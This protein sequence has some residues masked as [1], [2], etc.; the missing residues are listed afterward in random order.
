MQNEFTV[1]PIAIFEGQENFTFLSEA[2]KIISEELHHL[3]SDGLR[4]RG[5]EYKFTTKV[6]VDLA[7]LWAITPLECDYLHNL[8]VEFCPYCTVTCAKAHI[9][10]INE[11]DGVR[12]RIVPLADSILGVQPN[13]FIFCCLHMRMRITERLLLLMANS[14]NNAKSKKNESSSPGVSLLEA[15]LTELNITHLKFVPKKQTNRSELY[16]VELSGQLRGYELKNIFRTEI[17]KD[18]NE[19][20]A[21]HKI[22]N[23]E[24][25]ITNKAHT[26]AIWDAWSKIQ[27]YLT[28]FGPFSEEDISTLVLL[29]QSFGSEY[30]QRYLTS[31]VTPY[32]HILCSHLVEVIKLHG[33]VALYANEGFEATHKFHRRIFQRATAHNGSRSRVSSILQ[34]F[35][36]IYRLIL[37]RLHLNIPPQHSMTFPKLHKYSK[38]TKK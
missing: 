6:T 18:G 22:A 31:R 30:K 8:D 13:N 26:W 3:R 28:S 17:D 36:R 14:L 27:Y 4:W 29:L 9:F 19:T 20:A 12:K 34:T 24:P 1:F 15:V 2:L 37:L 7:G 11:A 16:S 33:S 25:K 10:G 21:W 38:Q 35:Q 32:V 23:L 5:E